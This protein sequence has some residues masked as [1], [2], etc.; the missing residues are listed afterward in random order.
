MNSGMMIYKPP[1]LSPP[2]N[3]DTRMY[4]QFCAKITN[5]HEMICGI[6]MLIRDRFLPMPSDA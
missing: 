4:T 2:R 5:S 6:A 1:P 3:R